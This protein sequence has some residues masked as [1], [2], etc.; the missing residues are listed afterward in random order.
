MVKKNWGKKCGSNFLKTNF[1]K[2]KNAEKDYRGSLLC[3][4]KNY[5]KKKCANKLGE[6]L[7]IIIDDNFFGLVW[8]CL[9][10]SGLA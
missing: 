10:W 9:V 5:L 8:S 3:E 2:K 7:K 4:N 6:T 1:G